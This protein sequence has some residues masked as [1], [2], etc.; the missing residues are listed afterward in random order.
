MYYAFVAA[1]ISGFSVFLNKFAVK[2]WINSS[3]FTT[4]KNIL[5]MV[6][7]FCL[8]LVLKK[9]PELKKI[10]KK[11]WFKLILIGLIGGSIPFLLF[12][13]G[14]S[15]ASATTA[16]FLHKTLFIWV[17]LL[18][19][20]FLKEKLSRIQ[21]GA[22]GLLVIGTYLLSA[23]IKLSFG[24]GE[25]LI[26]M[27]TILWAVENIISKTAISDISPTIVGWGR[28]FF[29]S[30]FLIIYLFIIGNTGGLIDFS[31]TKIEWLLLSGFILFAYV[32]FWYSSLKYIPVTVAS[33]ILTIAAPITA[34]LDSVFITHKIKT[35]VLL[36]SLIM[37]LALIILMRVS[38]KIM[39]K[40]NGRTPAIL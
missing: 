1:F 7:L 16:A 10:S 6:F 3:T 35:P 19:I 4:A 38:K 34:I 26:I 25:L 15:I 21:I 18:A 32:S 9:L 11:N 8:I 14:L 20:P 17:A 22:F 23:P 27:A 5:A 30:V 2:I 28:M 36:S 24:Y 40:T 33:S 29:G 31:T 39:E 37:T 12:F 13:K